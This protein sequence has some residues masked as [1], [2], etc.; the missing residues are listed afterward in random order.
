MPETAPLCRDGEGPPGTGGVPDP[1]AAADRPQAGAHLA[2]RAPLTALRRLGT[3]PR[4]LTEAEA[5]ERLARYGENAPPEWHTPSLPR[6]LLRGVRDP[7][8]AVLLCLAAVSTVV[9]SLG[10]AAVIAVLVS[11]S[12]LL[13]AGG[14]LRADRSVAGLRALVAGTVTVLRRA[15]AADREP[16]SREVPVG[17]LVPGDVIRLGP[18]DLVPADVL[19]LRA[20]GL[21]VHQAPLTGE[22]QPLAKYVAGPAE[23]PPDGDTRLFEQPQLCFQGSSVVAGSCTAVVLATG[24]DTRL[25]AGHR[26]RRPARS[27][28]ERSVHRVAWNLVRFML[29][30]P[31]LALAADAA[32]SGRGVEILPFAVTVAVSLTPEMLPVVMTAVL[33][34]NAVALARDRRVIVRR[35]PALHDLGAMDVLCLDKTGTLTEDRP[36]VDRAVGPDGTPD[37]EVL[38]WAA[39]NALW[40]LQLAETPVPDALDEAILRAAAAR[41]EVAGWDE[42]HEGVAAVP[43]DPARRLSTAVVRTP[44]RLGTHTLVVK[45]AVEAVLERCA[46]EEPERE[47]LRERA[48]RWADDGLRL[49]AVATAERPAPAPGKN[50]GTADERG[51]TFAGLVALRDTLTTDAPEAL[52]ALRDKGVEVKVLTGDHPGTAERTCRELGLDPAGGAVLT[53]DRIDALDDRQLA[54][55]AQRATLFARCTPHHKAR[56]VAALRAAGRTTGFLGDGVNDLAALRAADVGL[57]PRDAVA[58]VRESADVVFGE[59]PFAALDETVTAGRRSGVSLAS[60]LRVALSSN[61]GNALA[62]L[63]AVLLFPFMPMLPAQVLL[64]NLFFD[65]AQ[66][67]FAFDRHGPAALRAPAPLRPGEI[68]RFV[69]VFGVLNAAADMATFAVLAATVRGAA[70]EAGQALFHA[71]WFTENL[72]TQAMVMVLLRTRGRHRHRGRPGPVA[73][74][75]ALL[76]VT[77]LLLP[78]TPLG[79]ALGMVPALTPVSYALLAA[80]LGLYGAALAVAVRHYGRRLAAGRE[81]IGLA[82]GRG[83]GGCQP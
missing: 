48:A 6:R 74:A 62:M 38:R 61:F 20:T 35:L 10:T 53:A 80:V 45:G 70:G 33:A 47:A 37:A 78:L 68:L 54:G 8:T 50:Y 5:E 65:A 52:R 73:W 12:C 56:V 15:D 7:F 31:P 39:V 41:P 44:G 58:T 3:G 76:A 32:V 67:T 79:P 11:V 17:D 69:T 25:A 82:A 2:A 40:T 19:L 51:L 27:G 34:R 23:P 75:A 16:E 72:L 59:R 30:T 63:V 57:C 66:L 1:A 13:R 18:G 43:F 9:G 81:G 36:V 28:Y 4:G 64:Q 24:A 21:V 46:L 77:G 71:G 29:L 60:Y 22:S 14:E 83:A 26:H 49:L 55:A 42:E